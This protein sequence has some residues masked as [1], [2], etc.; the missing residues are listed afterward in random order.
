MTP[1]DRVSPPRRGRGAPWLVIALA[2]ALLATSCP[3]FV[4]IAVELGTAADGSAPELRFTYARTALRALS[5]LTIYGCPGD[6]LTRFAYDSALQHVPVVWRIVREEDAPA[7]AAQLRI[8]YGRVPA[9]YREE[10]PAAPIARGDCYYAHAVAFPD[11]S[12]GQAYIAGLEGG[13]TFRLL[14]DGRVVLGTP[15]I[16]L[17]D[18]RPLR[19]I[20]RAA[21]GCTRGYRRARTQADTAAVDARAYAVLETPVSCGHLRTRWPDVMRGPTTTERTLLGILGLGVS[22]LALLLSGGESEN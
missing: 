13:E 16:A 7:G 8:T 5:S 22:A 18:R 21:V 9:G 10:A 12:V 3:A 1:L 4:R 15:N 11:T 17:F 2:P 19:E 20:N 6:Q 14:S